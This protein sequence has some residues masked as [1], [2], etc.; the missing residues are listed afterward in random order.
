MRSVR[1]L[2]VGVDGLLEDRDGL[3]VA[4]L[5]DQREALVVEGGG[6]CRFG[7]AG[8]GSSGAAAAPPAPAPARSPPLGLARWF[9][10]LLAGA[11][12]RHFWGCCG[13]VGGRLRRGEVDRDDQQ[14]R[15]P[16]RTTRRARGGLPARSPRVRWM[17]TLGG[18]GAAARVGG[19]WRRGSSASR[20]GGLQRSTSSPAERGR[21]GRVAREPCLEHA[22]QVAAGASGQAS[23]MSGGAD[24]RR[25]MDDLGRGRA[26]V[27]RPR[28][29]ASRRRGPRGRRR[30]PRG[31]L[32]RRRRAARAPRRRACRGCRW[33]S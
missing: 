13:V 12:R 17:T 30:P 24:R 14:P 26:A 6:I 28:R 27:E 15:R 18:R 9:L 33:R 11:C 16:A 10:V 32:G 20:S 1:A 4:A 2:G 3:V 22:R 23:R 8:A 31:H 7:L 5:L 29:R 25:A 21:F 19:N